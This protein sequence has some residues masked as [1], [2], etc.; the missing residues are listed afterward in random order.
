LIDAFQKQL[1]H[2]PRAQL[3]IL[4]EGP[5]RPR[6]VK[7]IEMLGMSS[8]VTLLGHSDRVT[9]WLEAM[10]VFVLSSLREGLPN[11]LLEAL[12]LETPVVA[13]RIAGVP[14]LIAPGENGLLVTPGDVAEL[15]EAISTL[16]ADDPRRERFA[17]A[18]RE[19]I[20]QRFDFR[21]RMEKMRAIYD[22]LLAGV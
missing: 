16:L 5:E 17:R 10:N 1:A 2:D 12:A 7:Q 22:E 9:E 19:T 21:Q 11:V 18:G 20:C 6:L 8:R 15:G 14:E 13:T 3:V 4:G